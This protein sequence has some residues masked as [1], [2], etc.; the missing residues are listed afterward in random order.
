MGIK[1]PLGSSLLHTLSLGEKNSKQIK[2]RFATR[3]APFV[4]CRSSTSHCNANVRTYTI[5]NHPPKLTEDLETLEVC[6]AHQS[7]T[8]LAFNNI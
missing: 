2:S 8:V 7:R 3:N 6:E 4:K 1:L 5:D